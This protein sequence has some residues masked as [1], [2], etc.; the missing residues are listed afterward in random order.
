MRQV[1]DSIGAPP[2]ERGVPARTMAEF[3]NP[4]RAL[5]GFS[6]RCQRCLRFLNAESR[7]AAV[8]WPDADPHAPAHY[9]SPWK[10]ALTHA[11]HAFMAFYFEELCAQINWSQRPR[12]KEGLER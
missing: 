6:P 8:D 1:L 9:D 3:R 10:V 11:F 2:V 4:I 12:F 7:V 5:C